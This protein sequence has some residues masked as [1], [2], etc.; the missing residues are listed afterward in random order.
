M[1]IKLDI[2]KL[3]VE[4]EQ[5][6]KLH[7][8]KSNGLVNAMR[9]QLEQILAEIDELKTANKGMEEEMKKNQEKEKTLQEQIQNDK[10]EKIKLEQQLIADLREPTKF[11]EAA[12]TMNPKD[13]NW[14]NFQLGQMISS[15][16]PMSPMPQ[17]Q[18]PQY[19]MVNPQQQMY[20]Y[21]PYQ[22]MPMYGRNYPHYDNYNED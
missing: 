18:M 17:M 8:E 15:Q 20:P 11:L 12:K 5:E 3:K 6:A 9:T 13:L 14:I 10:L 4:K 1:D 21:Y 7:E 16:I 2:Q 22:M 19:P